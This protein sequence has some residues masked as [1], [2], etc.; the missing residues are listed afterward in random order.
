MKT[1]NWGGKMHSKAA[2]IDDKY[3]VI[4]SMNWTGKAELHN[5]ENLLIIN[6]AKVAAATK[7]HFLKLWNIIPNR[8]L[9]FD[10]SPESPDSIGSCMDGIDNNYNGY[11]DLGDFSCR[12]Y[13]MKLN[14][15]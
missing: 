15:R 9:H 7:Q 2:T 8:F 4:G 10:P 12:S 13:L 3:Y 11:A 14:Q 6:N 1:E 5:D